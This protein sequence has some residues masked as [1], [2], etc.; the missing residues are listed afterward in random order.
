M[1]HAREEVVFDSVRFTELFQ[2]IFKFTRS[3]TDERF[4]RQLRLLVDSDISKDDRE[5]IFGSSAKSRDPNPLVDWPRPDFVG[6]AFLAADRSGARF[7]SIHAHRVTRRP[8]I[9]RKLANHIVS[10]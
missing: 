3:L 4:E 5:S 2:R 7:S 6:G 1:A 9:I 8:Y 10:G